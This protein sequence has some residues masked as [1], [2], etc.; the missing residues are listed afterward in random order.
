MSGRKA[1]ALCGQWHYLE[2]HHVFGAANRKLSE[3]WGMVIELCPACHRTGKQLVH[4]CRETADKVKAHYQRIFM[5]MYPDEDFMAIFGR[6][7]L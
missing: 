5:H 3:K 1:C 7:Y 2:K 4:Q 6:N